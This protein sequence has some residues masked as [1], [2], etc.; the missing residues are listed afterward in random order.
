M[1]RDEIIA[2]GLEIDFS[3][4]RGIVHREIG[5]VVQSWTCLA[6]VWYGSGCRG[7]SD[8]IRN[9]KFLREWFITRRGRSIKCFISKLHM[10]FNK[11][12]LLAEVVYGS[13]KFLAVL[14]N[15]RSIPTMQIKKEI[16]NKDERYQCIEF[17]KVEVSSRAYLYQSV[18]G[19]TQ[20]IY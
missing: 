18:S 16:N 2:V 9:D 14:Y 19:Q 6:G 5:E 8:A 17:D 13:S 12:V 11:R 3:P 10:H 15:E 1:Y 7:A 20:T 4:L